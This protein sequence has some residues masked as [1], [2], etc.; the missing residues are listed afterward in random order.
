M[1]G[2]SLGYDIAYAIGGVALSPVWATSMLRTGKWRTD[3]PGRFGRGEVVAGDGPRVLIHAVSVGETNAIRDLVAMLRA[4]QP[5]VRVV[6]STTTDTGTARAREVFGERHAVVR[7]P[8]DFTPSVKRFLDRVRPDVVA[9]TELEVWPN[10][11]GECERRGI[12]VCVINGR[13]SENSFGGYQKLR[14]VLKKTFAKLAAVAAQTEAYAERFRAMGV[15]AERVRVL[16]TMKWDTAKLQD[17]SEVA[18]AEELAAEMGID[19][20][21][22]VVVAGSTAPGEERMLMEALPGEAQLVLVPRKPERFEEVA[23]LDDSMVRRTARKPGPA[24]V[25]EAR[26]FLLDTMGELRK[27]YALADVVVVGR[28]FVEFGGSD[29]IEPVALGRPTVI[30]PH[31]K[32]FADAVG[33]LEAGGG[34]VVAKDAAEAG[35]AVR[36]LL[37]DGER[38]ARLAAA[39]RAVILSRQGATRRHMEMLLGLLPTFRQQ[40]V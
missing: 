2:V 18:G 36:E 35:R 30:G 34:L 4:E 14:P 16:D 31:V 19:R 29:P 38:A 1:C 26:L 10:F 37:A 24:G 3:W 6:I 20:G 27:A 40:V 28:S 7:Y 22:P 23:G 13:L 8:F 5:G 25:P 32:N 33:A 39:G 12:K 17:A 11:V 21:R 15:P 9:L